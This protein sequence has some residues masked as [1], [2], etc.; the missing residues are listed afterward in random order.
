MT[1]TRGYWLD[2]EHLR[3]TVEP[4]GKQ[5]QVFVYDR[6]ARLV[7]Y[8][9]KRMTLHGAKTAAV[10]YALLHLGDPEHRQNP[11]EVAEALI[12]KVIGKAAVQ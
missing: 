12:W 10:E 1:A 9:A 4:D 5:W 7:I 2:L 6:I 3:L 8:R 11:E